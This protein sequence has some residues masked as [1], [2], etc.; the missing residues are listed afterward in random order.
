MSTM[1][2][3]KY[4]QDGDEVDEPVWPYRIDFEGINNYGWTDEYQ[5]SYLE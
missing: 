2:W 5:E 1:D 3:A 4:D